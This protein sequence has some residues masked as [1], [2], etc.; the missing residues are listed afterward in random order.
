MKKIIFL[1]FTITFLDA[2]E[3]IIALSPAINEIIFA[4]GKGDQIVGNTTYASYPQESQNI[5]KVGGYFSVSLEKVV[6]L[7]PSLILMQ[8][9]NLSLK[10]KFE[11]LGI[12]TEFISISSL[13]D[14]K[15]SIKKIAL[16][17][18]EKEKSK[19]IIKDIDQAIK[20]TKG[21]LENKKILI[22][23]G[24]Q[25]DLKKEIFVSGNGIYFADIIR[26]SGNKNAFSEQSTKQPILSYEG[27]IATNPD[28]IYILAHNLKKEE[29]KNLISSW[30]KLPINA[31]KTKTIYLTTQKYAGM[32]SQR[33]IKYIDDFREVLEDAKSKFT[34]LQD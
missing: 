2:R 32:P 15:D 9:N 12:K 8:K 18:N 17:L 30:L 16:L 23:F 28:I 21:I 11:K 4:I 6:S 31:T 13:Q 29:E 24:R 26:L 25:F 14:I 20:R 34:K 7:K 22:V 19:K 5:Y 1:L 3:R 33:V 10:P 27:I